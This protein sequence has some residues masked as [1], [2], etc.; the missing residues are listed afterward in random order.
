MLAGC[1]QSEFIISGQ[2]KLAKL[3]EFA[4][5]S[6]REEVRAMVQNYVERVTVFRDRIEVVFKVA[7]DF[8]TDKPITYNCES[9][10]SRNELENHSN[11][12]LPDGAQDD[13]C[14]GIPMFKVMGKQNLRR[15]RSSK[16]KKQRKSKV[17]SLAE[18]IRRQ[19]V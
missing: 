4:K 10:V 11:F 3:K 2:K 17:N 1:F 9:S 8:H 18:T 15:G 19:T 7:F 6:H 16:R 5:T 13:R 14:F 12:K